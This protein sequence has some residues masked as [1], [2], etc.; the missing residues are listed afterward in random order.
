MPMVC[1]FEAVSRSKT[2]Y[3]SFV[4]VFRHESL[5]LLNIRTC[6]LKRFCAE[7]FELRNLF[8]NNVK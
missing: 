7:C 8:T 6:L 3:V 1:R 5:H 2:I 4:R